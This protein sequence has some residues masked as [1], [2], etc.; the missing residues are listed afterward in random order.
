MT[1]NL[2]KPC[3]KNKYFTGSVDSCSACPTGSYS[4][5]GGKEC[6]VCVAGQYYDAKLLC[7]DCLPSFYSTNPKMACTKCPAN[8]YSGPKDTSYHVCATGLRVKVDQSGCESAT[9]TPP[10]S[11]APTLKECGSGRGYDYVLNKCV[12]CKP[13]FYHAGPEF[14]YDPN[15]GT[16]QCSP[17]GRNAYTYLHA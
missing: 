1:D 5:P 13:G 11:S 16:D 3:P 9:T 2:C 6:Q 10:P 17:C 8:K 12:Y 7:V 14:P 4:G 15:A